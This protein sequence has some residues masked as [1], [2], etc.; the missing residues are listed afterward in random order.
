M[1]EAIEKILENFV[2]GDI[3][4]EYY[5]IDDYQTEELDVKEYDVKV[6]VSPKIDMVDAEALQSR[7]ETALRMLGFFSIDG[8]IV[9]LEDIDKMLIRSAG[10]VK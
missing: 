7:L 1:K 5:T 9:Y 2:F 6:F 3:E 10:K 8:V 4:I